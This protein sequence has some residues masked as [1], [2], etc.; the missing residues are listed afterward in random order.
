MVIEQASID[1]NMVLNSAYAKIRHL[2]AGVP[3][4]R[5][6]RTFANAAGAY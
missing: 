2:E 5:K 4:H 6:T 1:I 3:T